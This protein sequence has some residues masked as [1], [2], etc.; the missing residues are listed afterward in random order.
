MDKPSDRK[1][2]SQG[3]NVR[4]RKRGIYRAGIV[5]AV[6]I[7][8]FFLVDFAVG[9]KQSRIL[10]ER[11]AMKK[12]N[13]RLAYYLERTSI[14]EI[15]Y[16]G[17]G[18]GYTMRL[19]FENVRPDEEMWI[20]VY[21]VK[22]FVQAGTLWKE[23]SVND[24]RMKRGDYTVERLNDPYRMTVKFDMPHKN[25]MELIPGHMHV[26]VNSLS[27]ISADAVTKQDII[28]KSE[29]MFIYVSTE[30]RK[31]KVKTLLR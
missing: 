18:N 7:A 29:D 3:G 10:E 5:L 13:E 31:G 27:Y 4:P 11:R 8:G 2:A 28:E 20:M 19:R 23:V 6:I 9:Y 25:F 22:V 15:T 1:V 30:K 12:K 21:A 16:T 24:M 14:E 17:T 26:K